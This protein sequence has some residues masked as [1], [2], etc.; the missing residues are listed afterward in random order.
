MVS[1]SAR[2]GLHVGAAIAT[3]LLIAG[4]VQGER[5]HLDGSRV[6]SGIGLTLGIPLFALF[7]ALFL[8]VLSSSSPLIRQ[9][10]AG[11]FFVAAILVSVAAA[12]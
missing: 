1:G 10:F 8:L 5:G 6:M 2:W 11:I 3:I 4:I 7:V 9:V 12:L